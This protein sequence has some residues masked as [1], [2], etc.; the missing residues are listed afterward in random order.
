M[1]QQFDIVGVTRLVRAPRRSIRR[2]YGLGTATRSYLQI[3]TAVRQHDFVGSQL[4]PVGAANGNV[5]ELFRVHHPLQAGHQPVLVVVVLEVAHLEHVKSHRY[6]RNTRL[7]A[8][9]RVIE[10]HNRRYATVPTTHVMG[11]PLPP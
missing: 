3:R 5:R 11:S 8:S 1:Q 4:V 10:R 2:R 6:S 9:E 7:D